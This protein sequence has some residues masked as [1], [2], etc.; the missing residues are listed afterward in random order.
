MLTLLWLG[1]GLF[2]GLIFSVKVVLVI[3]IMIVL[4]HAFA[5]WLWRP[6]EMAVLAYYLRAYEGLMVICGMWLIAVLMES[7]LLPTLWSMLPHKIFR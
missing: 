3:T 6:R 7:R 4:W 2:L 1:I 5:W